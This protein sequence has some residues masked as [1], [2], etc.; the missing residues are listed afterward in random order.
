[1]LKE[2]LEQQMGLVR[3]FDEKFERLKVIIGQKDSNLN[4]V[5]GQLE[6]QAEVILARDRQIQLLET[7]VRAVQGQLVETTGVMVESLD[8][9][10]DRF[11][12]ERDAEL[13]RLNR[14]VVERDRRIE[15]MTFE[16]EEAI[17]INNQVHEEE[18][19]KL[20]D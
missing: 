1:M 5:K 6:E 2:H 4:E 13:S 18:Q 10:R 8:D 16:R 14:Q 20:R 15:L 7:Q 3:D 12:K 9:Q 11:E 19:R 17:R